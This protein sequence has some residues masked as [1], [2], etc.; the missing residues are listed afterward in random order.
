MICPKC[1][2]HDTRVLDSRE[3]EGHKSVRRRRECEKCQNRFTTFER[4][5][6]SN[7]IV[8]KKDGTRESYDRE[9]VERGI[10]KACEKR[11]VTQDQVTKM[12]NQMEEKWASMG[13]EI[14]S[15]DVG[16]GIM[17]ALR[18]LDDVAYIRFASVYRQFKDIES[19]KKEL[20]KLSKEE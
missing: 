12:I 4:I 3:T 20:Q 6:T 13:K 2:Y 7:F 8:V 14:S 19:F 10:W 16:E 9:K 17:D 11:K 15:R 5:E 18:E 1:N